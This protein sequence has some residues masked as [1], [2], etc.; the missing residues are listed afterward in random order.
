MGFGPRGTEGKIAAARFASV[1][2]R[3][4]SAEDY[5]AFFE[6]VKRRRAG[7]GDED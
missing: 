6:A 3:F 4:E 5:A 2:G 1:Y 7:S